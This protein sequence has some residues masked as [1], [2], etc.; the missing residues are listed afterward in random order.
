[1]PDIEELPSEVTAIT[2]KAWLAVIRESGVKEAFVQKVISVTGYDTVSL[3]HKLMNVSGAKVESVFYQMFDE[4]MGAQEKEIVIYKLRILVDVIASYMSKNDQVDPIT[5]KAWLAVVDTDG[6]NVAFVQTV[7]AQTGYDTVGLVHKLMNA[8]GAKI[9]TVFSSMLE[10]DGLL[11]SEKN[12]LIQKLTLLVDAIDKYMD[13]KEESD[14]EK[15]VTNANKK[16]ERQDTKDKADEIKANKYKADLASAIEKTEQL[17]KGIQDGLRE[18]NKKQLEA[19]YAAVSEALEK[20]HIDTPALEDFEKDTESVLGDLQALMEQRKSFDFKNFY[21]T[22]SVDS[23]IENKGIARSFKIVG[24]VIEKQGVLDVKSPAADLSSEGGIHELKFFSSTETSQALAMYKKYGDSWAAEGDGAASGFIGEGLG[25]ASVKAQHT[26]TETSINSK[27]TSSSQSCT[28]FLGIYA[29]EAARLNVEWYDTNWTEKSHAAIKAVSDKKSALK[30]LE[31]YGTHVAKKVTLGARVTSTVSAHLSKLVST[32]SIKTAAD[33]AYSTTVSAS[34]EYISVGFGARLSGAL[35]NQLDTVTSEASRNDSKDVERTFKTNMFA[36]PSVML[37]IMNPAEFAFATQFSS[38]WEV[39]SR[40]NWAAVWDILPDDI[41]PTTQNFLVEAYRDLL[42]G[43]FAG[44]SDFWPA[45][46]S[47]IENWTDILKNYTL[48]SRHIHACLG[49]LPAF[50]LKTL[51]IDE[52][53]SSVFSQTDPSTITNMANPSDVEV[54]QKI[55]EE[56]LSE[57]INEVTFYCKSVTNNTY[58]SMTR[59]LS[60]LKA[61]YLRNAKNSISDSEALKEIQY[62]PIEDAIRKGIASLSFIEAGQYINRFPALKGMPTFEQ[63]EYPRYNG[64]FSGDI[65]TASHFKI[66]FNDVSVEKSSIGRDKIPNYTITFDW[67]YIDKNGETVDEYFNSGGLG[68]WAY[69]APIN[70]YPGLDI[71]GGIND[72]GIAIS[73]SGDY[74]HDID[75]EV[76]K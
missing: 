2:D 4:N 71:V 26:W 38:N 57:R 75:F 46:K 8:D 73:G 40:D 41:S 12:S 35:D 30:F 33:K 58:M 45:D 37:G 68:Q 24:D 29:Y 7:I 17:R 56:T 64:H 13:S 23:L 51:D 9:E 16:A 63:S 15:A 61:F 27:K 11:N 25:S 59:D 44:I 3:V 60:G 67:M 76:R 52:V 20:V 34:G 49:A 72:Y 43:E 22:A 47:S 42:I 36:K 31:T 54:F 65:S 66:R 69:K 6:V 28:D 19:S 10:R 1:M 53:Y 21:T 62:G 50:I 55:I 14:L 74:T 18:E 70:N 48:C 39:I 5:D 32:E